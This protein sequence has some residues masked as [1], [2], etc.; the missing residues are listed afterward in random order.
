MH[1]FCND[2]LAGNCQNNKYK[3]YNPLFSY[4]RMALNRSSALGIYILWPQIEIIPI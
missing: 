3:P 4:V 2:A 1:N